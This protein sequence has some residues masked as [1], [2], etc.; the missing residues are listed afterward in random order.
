MITAQICGQ[1]IAKANNNILPEF[2]NF[3]EVHSWNR[4]SG[5]GNAI[6][7][8]NIGGRHSYYGLGSCELNF[9]GTSEVAFNSGGSE[10]TTVIQR[11]GKYVLSYAFDKSDITS[12]ITFTVE[13]FVN[14][15]LYSQNTILQNLYS[16]SGFVDGQ[17]TCYYQ[18]ILLEYGDII[19]FSFKAQSDTI[20]AKL[21]FD[22]LKLEIDDRGSGYPT[23]YSEAPLA[24]IEEE[25]TITV[26]L[27]PTG[28]SVTI[29]ASITGARINNSSK[30]NVVMTYPSE[31]ITL[32]LVVSD[33]TLT[34]DNVAKFVIFNPT[35]SD[36][37]PTADGIYNLKI[38][39]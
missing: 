31:L 36:V 32:G 18:S 30:R 37:T 17:W 28:E 7:T 33:V 34:A 12:D 26:G 20:G 8:N 2:C 24:T 22:R 14:G 23:I 3:S 4:T 27:I 38:V 9:T 11:D 21:W 5:S 25:N 29:T 19:T 15:T 1:E 6:I 39:R 10:M 16:T 35:G 13:F